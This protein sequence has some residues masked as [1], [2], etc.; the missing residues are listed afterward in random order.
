MTIKTRLPAR[1]VARLFAIGTAIAVNAAAL[2]AVHTAL[3]Q[4]TV[5]EQL[6]QLEPVRI[7]VTGPRYGHSVMAIQNCPA[8]GVL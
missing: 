6:A 8:P 3:V 4:I 5:H 2:A 1:L 7:V